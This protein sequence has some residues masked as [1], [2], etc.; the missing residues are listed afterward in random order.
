MSTFTIVDHRLCVNGQPVPYRPTPNIGGH[1]KPRYLVMHFTAGG[2]SGA[3]EWLC[4]PTAKASAHLVIGENGE[5]TQLAPF[6]RQTWHAGRSQW[7]D[8]VGLNSCSI[9]IELANYGQLSGSRGRYRFAGKV[10]VPDD[11]VVEAR[12]ANG[13]PVVPWHTYP[14][15]QMQVARAVARA[16]HAEY[17]FEDVLGHDQIAPGRKTDPGPLFD[18]PAFRT[19]TLFQNGTNE[20]VSKD[21]RSDGGVKPLSKS[22]TIVGAGMT[23]VGLLGEP[24]ADAAKQLEPLAAMSETVKWL[25]LALS[26]VGVALVVYA[27]WDDSRKGR[28]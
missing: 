8:V 13:G 5:I 22:R 2:Y 24:I 21:D 17:G 19:L 10:I 25:F 23:S 7:R 26:V 3:V 9:G 6:D 20:A 1:L 11:R 4:N 15:K 14:E 16:L 27:R 28:R 12:H 18:M